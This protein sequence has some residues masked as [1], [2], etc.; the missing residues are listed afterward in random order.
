[1]TDAEAEALLARAHAAYLVWRETPIAERVRLFGR[2][3]DLVES[4]SEELAR[5][6][7]LEM[8]KPLAQAKGE[9]RT[10]AA[11]FRYYAEYGEELQPRPGD[12]LAGVQ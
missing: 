4:N 9:N 7:T 6:V 1:M 12:R 5:L 3:A 11:M 8:G 10:A 2:F